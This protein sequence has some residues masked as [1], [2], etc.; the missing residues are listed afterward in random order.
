M[1]DTVRC[2]A[3]DRQKKGTRYFDETFFSPTQFYCK[4]WNFHHRLAHKRQSCVLLL[5]GAIFAENSD[6]VEIIWFS[7]EAFTVTIQAVPFPVLK[8]W[9]RHIWCDKMPKPMFKINLKYKNHSTYWDMFTLI[10]CFFFDLLCANESHQV[11][12]K[13]FEVKHTTTSQTH[14]FFS[15]SIYLPFCLLCLCVCAGLCIGTYCHHQAAKMSEK[16][17][18]VWNKIHL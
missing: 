9:D 18:K 5:K 12:A 2:W 6:K 3:R 17:S 8:T 1:W 15:L 16:S 13:Y 14:P 4:T 11:D 7:N 10:S